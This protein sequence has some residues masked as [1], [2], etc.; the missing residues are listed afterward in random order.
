MSKLVCNVA[1]F[2]GGQLYGMDIHIQ[3][4]TNNHSNKDIDTSRSNLNYELVNGQ[5]IEHY[6]TAVKKRISQGYTGKKEL[7]KDA[8]LACGVLISSDKNFFDNLTEEQ[9]RQFF[10]T[11]YEHLCETYGKENIISAKVHKDE[12]TPHLHAI[13]VPLTKDGRLTAKELFDRKALTTLHNEI[14]KKLKARGFNIERGEK[15]ANVKR[16]ETDE[17]KRLKE[18]NKVSVQIDPN[19]IMLYKIGEEK[20]LFGKKDILETQA[21]VAKRLEQK[22]IEPLAKELTEL[23]TEKAIEHAKKSE[24]EWAKRFSKSYE[25]QFKELYYSVREFGSEHVKNVLTEIKGLVKNLNAKKQDESQRLE[26]EKAKAR[27]KAK[28]LETVKC[29]GG[30]DDLY[31]IADFGNAPYRFEENGEPSFYIT[32]KSLITEKFEH[33]W[34]LQY[35]EIFKNLALQIGSI[36]HLN[37]DKIELAKERQKQGLRI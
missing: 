7:R 19:E 16:L 30:S 18:Q 17:Y 1:K 37:G 21:D 27:E 23:R 10:Q 12:T 5:R 26:Q 4:K 13:V 22:Y 36:V 2:K 15:N 33:R 29:Y 28:R 6:F 11:A 20:G 34:G 24:L 32:L 35:Q 14:P 25:E 31:E 9:E 8:T 3:R